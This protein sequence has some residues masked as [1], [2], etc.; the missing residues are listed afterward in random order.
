MKVQ[1]HGCENKNCPTVSIAENAHSE[2]ECEQ[3]QIIL[4]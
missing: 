2:G 4:L 3:P 1:F